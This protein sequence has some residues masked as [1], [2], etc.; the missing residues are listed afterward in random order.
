MS[1]H[2]SDMLL[3]GVALFSL[4]LVPDYWNVPKYLYGSSRCLIVPL[5]ILMSSWTYVFP[6]FCVLVAHFLF[7]TSL[8]NFSVMWIR[9]F[10]SFWVETK[11]FISSTKS[12]CEV[13]W[14]FVCFLYLKPWLS[15]FRRCTYFILSKQ[16]ICFKLRKYI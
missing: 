5:S 15:L 9:F 12:R 14:L 11:S 7:T 8:P 16:N 4:K 10:K 6:F 3:S 1:E 13:D 2:D